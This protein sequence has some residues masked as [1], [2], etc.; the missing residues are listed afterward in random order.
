MYIKLRKD[1]IVQKNLPRLPGCG[2]AHPQLKILSLQNVLH[3]FISSHYI[4]VHIYI[5]FFF[6]L[7]KT[8]YLNY[9]ISVTAMIRLIEPS[10]VSTL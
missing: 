5:N 9:D 1:N 6:K 4:H 10:I 3:I 2:S 7:L 8:V